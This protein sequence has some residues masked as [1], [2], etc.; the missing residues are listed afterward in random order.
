MANT[1][2]DVHNKLANGDIKFEVGSSYHHNSICSLGIYI[3]I[4]NSQLD[5]SDPDECSY[6][7]TVLEYLLSVIDPVELYKR[8]YDNSLN[9]LNKISN[10]ITS[11]LNALP[12]TVNTLESKKEENDENNIIRL[13]K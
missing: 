12:R 8:L 3:P 9:V 13:S 11:Q 2:A 10:D 6:R 4:A 5:R 1:F 7:D